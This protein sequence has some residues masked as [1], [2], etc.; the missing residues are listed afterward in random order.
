M[1]MIVPGASGA[2][3]FWRANLVRLDGA[4]APAALGRIERHFAPLSVE[5][6][7]LAVA[8]CSTWLK[9]T[10]HLEDTTCLEQLVLDEL[11][12]ELQHVAGG[13]IG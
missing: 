1:M 12:M 6:A 13:H 10:G 5:N 3:I 2:L 4:G 7:G 11:Q 8:L 9:K